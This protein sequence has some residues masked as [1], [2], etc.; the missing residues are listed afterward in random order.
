M[1]VSAIIVAGGKGLR[2]KETTRKQYL[3]LGD[4]PIL[5][6]TLA[7]F[8]TCDAVN[9]IFLVIPEPDFDFCR[10]H[11]LSFFKKE[12][13]LVPGGKER[14]DSVYN[15]LSALDSD[16]DIVLIHDGV[17]PFV[18]QE[19]IRACIRCAELS[20]ACILGIPAFDTL[21]QIA[22]SGHIESTLSRDKIWLA[23]T[24]QAFRYDL[25]LA[26]HESARAAGYAGTDEA[27]LLERMGKK[28]KII[29]GSRY[30]IKITAP[31][32]LKLAEAII[33]F[34]P[35]DPNPAR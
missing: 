2:M 31:E 1:R 20:G 11:I 7:V 15:G 5:T 26:A 14:Q 34:L 30:N 12:I 18:Q 23:Q 22:D 25:I 4:R 27:S 17:R 3:L 33:S 8:D 10:G 13:R 16:T 24:P 29:S 19:Q 6:H 9:E 35:R 28:V 32:D 21:K